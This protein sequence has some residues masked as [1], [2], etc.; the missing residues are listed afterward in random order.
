MAFSLP[1]F[2]EDVKTLYSGPLADAPP[3]TPKNYVPDGC[4]ALLDAV[5]AGMRLV[6]GRVATEYPVGTPVRVVVAI[7]TDGCEN[8]ST[9]VRMK[10]VAR[11]IASAKQSDWTFHFLSSDRGFLGQRRSH[12][13]T[14]V[15]HVHRGKKLSP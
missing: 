7:L 10:D 6:S 3:L 1:L 5:A 2:N 14:E 11:M 15:I 4:T 9:V 8:S 13:P 12:G